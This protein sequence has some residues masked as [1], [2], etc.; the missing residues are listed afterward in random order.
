MVMEY[1]HALMEM[2]MKATIKKVI[3]MEMESTRISKVVIKDSSGV[4]RWK[5]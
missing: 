5:E 2:S 4:I 1:I 3:R